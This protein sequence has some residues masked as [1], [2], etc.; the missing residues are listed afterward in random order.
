MFP[1]TFGSADFRAA[2]DSSEFS[3]GA[4]LTPPGLEDAPPSEG[5]RYHGKVPPC[6]PQTSVSQDH[7]G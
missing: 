2:Q 3:W 6:V 4:G 5:G 1:D 7:R